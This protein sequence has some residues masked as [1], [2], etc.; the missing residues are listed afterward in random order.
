[1]PRLT[2]LLLLG[3]AA[4]CSPIQPSSQGPAPVHEGYAP[5]A[6]GM[7]LFYRVDGQ[8]PDTVI[9]LHGGPSLGIA[10]LAP[11]LE[12]LGREYTLL[13][14]DQRGVGRSTL[15]ADSADLAIARHVEDLEALRRHFALDR[16]VLVGHSWGGMLAARYAAAYPD[17]VERMLFIDPMVPAR[18]PYMA[19]AGARAQQLM[20]ERLDSLQLAQLDSLARSWAETE[21]PVTH[22]RAT[23][24]IL[25]RVFFQDPAGAE[26][27]RGDFCGGSAEVLRSRPQV[28]AAIMGSLGDWDVRP[29]LAAVGVPVLIVHGSG[30]AIPPEAMQ[31]WARAFPN[32]RLMVV[33]DAGHYLHVDRP[34]VFFPAAVEFLSGGWPPP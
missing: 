14:Y 8:G 1:M 31:E 32:A 33:P 11:D 26:R 18:T 34:A 25:F 3:L 27:A 4:A 23:F 5:G 19:Q 29:L 9:I 28:D 7:R 6:D 30:S 16:L 21:D 22:C 17:H 24:G 2:I 13:Y 12:A 15:P 10:Y 20:H